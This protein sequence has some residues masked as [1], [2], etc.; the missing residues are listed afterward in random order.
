MHNY[1]SLR[2]FLTDKERLFLSNNLEL[3]YSFWTKKIKPGLQY[4]FYRFSN[5]V[6]S[7]IQFDLLYHTC[8]SWLVAICMLSHINLVE[9]ICFISKD[10]VS[11]YDKYV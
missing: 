2:I 10:F 1:T 7:I 11:L 3:K 5:T 4:I 9:Q 8:C 6:C